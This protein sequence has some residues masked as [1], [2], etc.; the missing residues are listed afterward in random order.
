MNTKQIMTL[1]GTIE[2]LKKA[3][4]DHYNNFIEFNRSIIISNDNK[5]ALTERDARLLTDELNEAIRPI[6]EKFINMYEVQLKSI[7]K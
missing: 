4:F 5:Y 1:S 6:F 3:K 2:L 7:I